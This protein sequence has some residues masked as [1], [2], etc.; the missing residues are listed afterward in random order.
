MSHVV[1]VIPQSLAVL[2]IMVIV[3]VIINLCLLAIFGLVGAVFL[4]RMHIASGDI[5]QQKRE[6]HQKAE[7]LL[8][9]ARKE[10]L[11]IVEE[12]NKK[13]GEL[14]QQTQIVKETFETELA[15]VLQEFSQKETERVGHI[16]E[17]LI[18]NYRVMME[19]TKQKYGDAMLM[20]AKEMA[21]TAQGSLTQFQ[22]YLKDQTTRYEST[23]KQ[24]T[25][26]GFMSAQK[27]ISDYKRESFRK[28]ED[29]IYRI[30][31]LVSKSVFGKAVS[32]EDQQDLVIHALDEAKQQGFF[33]L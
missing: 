29:A 27:E 7:V 8:E 30:L 15:V 10:S 12:A 16:S 19:S 14:L 13:A 2:F 17:E 31:D 3:V 11:H 32:L 26:T 23:L 5:E 28:V 18:K 6:I 22:E 25:Q 1:A 24:Q 21:D 9:N 4:R 33:E 20:A